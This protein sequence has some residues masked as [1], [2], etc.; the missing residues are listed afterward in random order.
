MAHS[1][2]LFLN[3]LHYSDFC[4]NCWNQFSCISLYRTL[5]GFILVRFDFLFEDFIAMERL[6]DIF[7]LALN[8]VLTHC[9]L[10]KSYKYRNQFDIFLDKSAMIFHEECCS[11][12]FHYSF[13]C[14]SAFHYFN[15]MSVPTHSL[16]FF[17]SSKTW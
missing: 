1:Q 17:C 3:L 2:T 4:K 14:F 8:A 7:E 11:T 12:R 10:I 15:I 9:S 5:K 6:F 13:H 16:Q